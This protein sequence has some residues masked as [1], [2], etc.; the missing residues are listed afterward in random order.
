MRWNPARHKQKGNRSFSLKRT[1]P[2]FIRVPS[3]RHSRCGRRL[4]TCHRHVFLTP[5]PSKKKNARGG[6]AVIPPLDP[7]P[8]YVR[9]RTKAYSVIPA[10]R[11]VSKTRRT[12]P[13]RSV[14]RDDSARRV[15]GFPSR[16]RLWAGVKPQR[17]RRPALL[18]IALY[19]GI[20]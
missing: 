16:G 13:A 11:P 1:A 20:F 8:K 17:C 3:S 6:S 12:V 2:P 19:Y 15:L 4:K 18:T 7:T 5:R 9:Q 10:R 14:G